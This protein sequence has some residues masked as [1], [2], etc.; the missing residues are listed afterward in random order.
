[1][2]IPCGH[3]VLLVLDKLE[4]TD[5]TF[6]SAKLAGIEIPKEF[7]EVRLEQ[8]AVDRGV[9]V[10][11]GS[12]AF[13]DFGG[14]PWCAV[15]DYIAFARHSGKYITDPGTK[16]EFVLINDEDIVCVIKGAKT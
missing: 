16:E 2:L 13:K 15:G 9:V 5:E 6:K 1:M 4:E 12:T 8:N 11:I 14:E 7:R 3:R 10:S